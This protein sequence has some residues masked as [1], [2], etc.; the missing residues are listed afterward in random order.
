MQEFQMF[1]QNPLQWLAGRGLNVP[2]NIAN[3]PSAIIQHLMNN[4]QITQA[5]YNS[6]AQMA[7]QFNQRG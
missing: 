3:N 1:R 4:G 5:Q 6:A 7:R 2:A